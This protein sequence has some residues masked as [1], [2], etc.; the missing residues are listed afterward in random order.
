MVW[1]LTQVGSIGCDLMCFVCT[2]NSSTP[3]DYHAC[4]KDG[5]KTLVLLAKAYFC[6]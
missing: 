6:D 2:Y 1:L 5:E 4:V 3:F